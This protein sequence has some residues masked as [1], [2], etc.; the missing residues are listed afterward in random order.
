MK[1]T[2]KAIKS[3]NLE[4]KI[5]K[6]N[7]FQT[8]TKLK[9]DEV[10][11]GH[12]YVQV[13]DYL[14]ETAHC[15]TFIAE[16]I[17]EYINNHH[18]VINKDQQGEMRDTAQEVNKFFLEVIQII[19]NQEYKNLEKALSM[20]I[21]LLEIFT[22]LKKKQLKRIKNRETGMKNSTIYL[23]TI[24]E[25]KNLMLFI[26]NLLKAQ[27]DFVVYSNENGSKLKVGQPGS[28]N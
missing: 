10:E 16:P 1:R 20:Q 25:S 17:Y 9:E 15:L 21:A 7:V 28:L 14:S 22:R 3:L 26:I 6:D 11:S 27:R 18:P 19:K 8:I 12:Y 23:N 5:L 2:L 4:V 13:I 24:T